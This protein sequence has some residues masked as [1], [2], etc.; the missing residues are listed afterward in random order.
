MR[1]AIAGFQHETNTFVSTPTSLTDFERA[2]SWPALLVGEDVLE[3]TRGMNLPIAGFAAAATKHDLR[4][5]LWCA[6]EPGGKVMTSA[7]EN[8]AGRIT[9]AIEELMPL[10]AVFLDLH[11]AMVTENSDDGEGELLSRIRQIVGPDVPLVASLDMHANISKKMVDSANALTI[12][13]TYPHLDMAETGARAF[14][15]IEAIRRDGRPE[16]V[17]RQGEFLIPLHAQQTG[18]GPARALYEGLDE[19]DGPGTQLAEIA[20]GFTAA[21]IHDT[22]PSLVVY[23]PDR[24]KAEAICDTLSDRLSSAE[25]EFDCPLLSP[26]E[27]VR[28]AKQA[29]DGYPI[30]IADVQDNPGAGASSDTTG[31]LRELIEQN[32]PPTLLG[33]LHDPSLAIAAHQAGHGATFDA[34]IGGHG[35]GDEPVQAKVL[36]HRLSEGQCAYTGEMYGGGVATL[37]PSAAL[38]LIGTQIQIVVTSVRNQCLD[39]AQFRH[40]GLEPEQNKILCVKSTAHFRADFEPI[41]QDVLLCAAP[42]QFPCSLKDVN[43]RNLRPD[44]RT[45]LE[46]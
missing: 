24:T 32:A 29:P 20:L 41:A 36:V 25:P 27:A 34:T 42:G 39:L 15:M 9:R 16:K 43:Y 6:A 11:G 19:F 28:R 13:R 21:D 14:R 18:A 17:W 2:D 3:T 12:Y 5:I 8:I 26:V 22:G 30:V 35:P 44:V 23:G 38:R 10:D 45:H 31:L 7:F 33:L 4:P 1:I 46:R 37:G 40:F